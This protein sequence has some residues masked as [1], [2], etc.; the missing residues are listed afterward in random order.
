MRIL[1]ADDSEPVR[2][3]VTSI[4]ASKPE[5]QVCGTAADGAEAIQKAQELHPDLVLLDVSMPGIS[6]LETARVLRR[7]VPGAVI[8]IMSQ[9]DP[10]QLLPNALEA[11]AQACV[12]KS[13][14][15]KDL[16]PAIEKIGTLPK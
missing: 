12:D 8:V 1:V 9:H 2:R 13:R 3:G 5:W 10:A 7:E 6:G 11:G 15:A 14:L 16:V 4:L